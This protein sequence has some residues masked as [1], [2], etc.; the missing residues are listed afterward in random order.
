MAIVS[1]F[2]TGKFFG[3]VEKQHRQS[4][5]ITLPPTSW[6]WNSCRRWIVQHGMA[7]NTIFEYNFCV[8]NYYISERHRCHH[9]FLYTWLIIN[10]FEMLTIWSK[11][12]KINTVSIPKFT[13]LNFLQQRHGKSCFKKYHGNHGKHFSTLLS[14]ITFSTTRF[15]SL[16]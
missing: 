10:L 13:P 8:P 2:L 14:K 15:F 9:K 3:M 7:K 5:A 12:R 4:E 11:S 16:I 1:Y 6:R